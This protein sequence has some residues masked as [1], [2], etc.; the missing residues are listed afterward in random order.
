[1]MDEKLFWQMIED[2]WKP[3]KSYADLRGIFGTDEL[4]EDEAQRLQEPLDEVIANLSKAL[5]QLSADDLLAFDRILEK[6]LFDIDRE[7]VH[8]YT[9]GSDDGFLYAR[10]FIVI[11]GEKYYNAVNNDPLKAMFDLECEMAC[12]L[13]LKIY[14]EKFGEMP[15][16]NISRESHANKAGWA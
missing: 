7:D 9:D 8:E 14:E 4:D 11:V 10:G 6:K 15:R 3:I 16:S 5:H 2:A 13:P 1:M 12:Y